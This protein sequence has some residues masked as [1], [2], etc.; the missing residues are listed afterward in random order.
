MDANELSARLPPSRDDEPP[1]LRQ[2]ILDELADH[3][4][5]AKHR[6]MLTTN[7]EA[8]AEQRVLD[9]FGDPREVARK[10]W[11]QAMWSRIMSQR[12]LLSAMGALVAICLCLTGALLWELQLQR[13]SMVEQQR[14]IAETFEKLAGLAE[15][16]ANA[17]T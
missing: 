7:D 14:L 9:K 1:S 6:E 12:W 17:V 13:A 3:L 2:D 16:K 4:A 15:S 8:K 5:C 11:F 10:L